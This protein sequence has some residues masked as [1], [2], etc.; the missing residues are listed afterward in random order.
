LNKLTK[1][2]IEELLVALNDELTKEGVEGELYLVGGAVMCLAFA[3]RPSTFDVDA[4][5]EPAS[6][7]RSAAKRVAAQLGRSEDWLNDGVKGFLSDKGTF[8]SYLD[9][10]HL[11]VFVAKPE[12]LL[13]MKCLAMRIGEEFRDIDDVRYLL[14]NLGVE[15]YEQ[16]LEIITRFYPLEKF[17][18]KAVYVLQELL[19]Q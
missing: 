14:R 8:S 4:Y 9:L 13:A 7:V 18:Q 15:S 16:A 3:A 17:P 2:N 10:S 19:P 1:K 5:F 6:K 12:Y 11:R